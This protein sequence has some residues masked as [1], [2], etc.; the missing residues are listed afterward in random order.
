MSTMTGRRRA[1]IVVIASLFVLA[2]LFFFLVPVGKVPTV[3]G[4]SPRVQLC[5]LRD[6]TMYQLLAHDYPEPVITPLPN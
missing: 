4:S 3:C 5:Q 2:A 1:V 6:V